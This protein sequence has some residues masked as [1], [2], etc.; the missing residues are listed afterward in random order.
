MTTAATSEPMRGRLPLS[1]LLTLSI[2]WLGILTIW[3]GLDNV[4]IP[5]RLLDLDRAAAGTL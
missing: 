2:Y 4:V 1:Q 5:Q 3:G